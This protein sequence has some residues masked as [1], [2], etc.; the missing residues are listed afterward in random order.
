MKTE[1]CDLPLETVL[2]NVSAH[3]DQLA[4]RIHDLEETLGE[5]LSADHTAVASI[6][7]FQSLDFIRQSLEDCA[8]LVH[9]LSIATATTSSPL[10]RADKMAPRLKLDNTK[11]LIAVKSNDCASSERGDSVGDVDLF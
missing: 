11:T 9:Y 3:L 4:G 8:M 5:T 2:S 1:P 6:S 7:K 10:V